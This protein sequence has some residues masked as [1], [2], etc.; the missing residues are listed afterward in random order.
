M[1]VV[2][3]T[4][5]RSG[6]KFLGSLL[7]AKFGMLALGE[8]FNPDSLTPYSYRQFVLA[9]GLERVLKEGAVPTLNRYFQGLSELGAIRQLD[10]MFNQIAWP[11]LGWNPYAHEF[12]HG[13][14][15]S[16]DAVVLSL[17]R[18]SHDVFLSEKTLQIAGVPHVFE[19]SGTAKSACDLAIESLDGRRVRLDAAEYASF[20]EMLS[21][22]RDR[23]R[24]VFSGYRFFAEIEYESLARAGS[25]DDA[26]EDLIRRAADLHRIP[27]LPNGSFATNRN[28][29]RVKPEYERLF[30]NLVD[31]K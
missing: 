16:C 18:N 2:T 17:I 10:V 8:V 29:V 22:R 19:R 31:L 28:P 23:L 27:Q 25:I 14:L 15:M 5:Q 30:D 24:Q 21:I 13:Y 1:L 26:T 7:R 12:L 4:Q 6:S 3:I 9:N 11:C 20:V